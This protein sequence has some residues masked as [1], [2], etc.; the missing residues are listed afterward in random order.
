MTDSTAID[1]TA[2]DRTATDNGVLPQ[3]GDRV[4][5]D[6]VCGTTLEGWCRAIGRW[7]SLDG[8]TALVIET[9]G[10]ALLPIA[11][12]DDAG[13]LVWRRLGLPP[14]EQARTLQLARIAAAGGTPHHTSITGGDAQVAAG[15]LALAGEPV[16][17]VQPS[18]RKLP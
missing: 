9:A 12:S 5:V 13:T 10:G 1:S 8:P 15:F 16:P 3:I 4:A 2:I 17:P 14:A 6:L 11:A 7:Q 18:K